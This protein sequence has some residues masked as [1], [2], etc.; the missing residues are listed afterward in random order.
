MQRVKNREHRTDCTGR[1]NKRQRI[2]PIEDELGN[3][4][5]AK[6]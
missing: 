3:N 4:S 1:L 6:P 2:D 5:I